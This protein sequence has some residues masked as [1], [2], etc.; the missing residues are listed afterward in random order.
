MEETEVAVIGAGLSGLCAALSLARLGRRV[1][2]I[3]RKCSLDQ[4][5]HTTG[6]FVRRTLEDFYI[7][8]EMLGPAVRDVVLYSP[9]GRALGLRSEHPEFRVGRMGAI[10][11]ALVERAR[12]AGVEVMLGTRFDSIERVGSGGSRVRLSTGAR[13]RTLD[14]RLVIGADGARS[15]VSDALGLSRNRACIVGAEHVYESTRR[16]LPPTFHCYLSARYAPGYLAWVI[17]D[18][19]EMHV[20]VG[21]YARRFNANQALS[22]FTGLVGERFEL[23]PSR[24]I[25]KRGGLV[26][27]GG[28][29]KRIACD[30]GLLVGDAAGAVSPLTAGGL[31]P[32]FR[33]S[34]HAAEVADAFLRTGDARVLRA[35]DGGRMRTRFISRLWMRRALSM[36]QSDLATEAAC[37][38]MRTPIGRLAAHHVFFGRGS[39]PDVSRNESASGI[40]RAWVQPF[41]C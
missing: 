27:V 35:Y 23:D 20:G 30:G 15:R 3:D 7:P 36:L 8:E 40:G 14:A 21:G 9:A 10:Y 38:M 4:R 31:D 22:E 19:A 25:E 24:L 37:M 28:V 32:C 16:V 6:I 2:I 33:L 5:V 11:N 18:G 39:F 17:D 1:T 34:A 29:L 41:E 13:T 12:R 26:P